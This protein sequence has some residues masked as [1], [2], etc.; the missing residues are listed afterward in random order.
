MKLFFNKFTLSIIKVKIK[1]IINLKISTYLSLKKLVY[2]SQKSLL[3][4]IEGKIIPFKIS[5]T[6]NKVKRK[7]KYLL[8]KKI[9][10]I[11]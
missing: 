9:H 4:P 8:L 3:L 7:I 10:T 2:C 11:K 5:H 1:E 6:K